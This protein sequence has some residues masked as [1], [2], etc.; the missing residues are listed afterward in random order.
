MS[1]QIRDTIIDG[2]TIVIAIWFLLADA[3]IDVRNPVANAVAGLVMAYAVI[4]IAR[5]HWRRS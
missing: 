4:R 5:R 1:P 2:A 3:F